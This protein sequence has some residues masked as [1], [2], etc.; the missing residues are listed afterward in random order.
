[1]T[2]FL[3][4]PALLKCVPD[5]STGRPDYYREL[6]VVDLQADHEIGEGGSE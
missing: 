2:T 5:S 1:M 6:G 3:L 4:L